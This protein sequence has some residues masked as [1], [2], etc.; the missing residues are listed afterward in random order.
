VFT[1]GLYRTTS[2]VVNGSEGALV[3]DPGIL[4]REIGAIAWYVEQSEKPARYVVYTHH[5]WDH[6]LGGQSF[7]AARRLAHR[8]FPDA[9]QSNRPLD[10]IR[11]FDDE[12]YIDRD[13]PF[14]FQPPHELVDDGWTGSLGDVEFRLLYLPGHAIDMLGVHIPAEKTL[15]AADMLSDVEL[16]M[17]EGDGSSY[18]AS[19]RKID[20]L[21]VN[22]E[23]ETLVPGHGRVTSGAE[24]IRTRVAEDIAY[25]DRLRMVIGGKLADGEGAALEACRSMAYRG[26]DGRPPMDSVHEDNARTIYRAMQAS[27]E[28]SVSR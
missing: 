9:M 16:P 13:P 4:P 6:I 3:I 14:Q 11:R 21:V 28:A 26:K 15:F 17:I 19:L 25:I 18:L 27:V 8:C 2:G 22:G 24:A 12:Y 1:S 7:P 5:H 20:A 10:E 23:V